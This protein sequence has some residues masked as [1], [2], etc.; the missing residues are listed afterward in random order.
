MAFK[1]FKE[2]LSQPPMSR[3]EMDE[4]LFSY[5]AMALHAVSLV[6]I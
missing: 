1:Q 6:L 3:L 2:Y 4:I 5:I